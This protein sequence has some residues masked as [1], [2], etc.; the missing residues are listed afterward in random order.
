MIAT[1]SP[2]Q[3]NTEHTLNTL[4]YAYRV[5]EIRREEEGLLKGEGG[6]HEAAHG[7]RLEG[8]DDDDQV[9]AAIEVPAGLSNFLAAQQP[10]ILTRAPAV[11][12]G[13]DEDGMG[14]GGIV[15]GGEDV[16]GAAPPAPPKQRAKLLSNNNK[17]ATGNN[18]NGG[19]GGGGGVSVAS[20]A[21]MPQQSIVQ[22]LPQASA[23]Q[24][25][26]TRRAVSVSA[27]HGSALRPPTSRVTASDT[28]PHNTPLVAVESG[29][30]G[31]GGGGNGN[32]GSPSRSSAPRVTRSPLV[33]DNLRGG[34]PQQFA[35]HAERFDNL[36][37]DVARR[38]AAPR[39]SL[40]ESA[41]AAAAAAAAEA[42]AIAEAEAEAE[43]IAATATATAITAAAASMASS[44][45]H[46][47]EYFEDNGDDE[48]DNDADA[49]GD[50]D[51]DDDVDDGVDQDVEE[52]E[53]EEGDIN[54]VVDTGGEDDNDSLSPT[55]SPPPPPPPS[56]VRSPIPLS[57]PPSSP[58]VYAAA[59]ATALATRIS[60]SSALRESARLERMRSVAL[61]LT[62][63][64]LL[65]IEASLIAAHR[66]ALEESAALTA[67]ER[68]LLQE[69]SGP[70]GAL[71]R[72]DF[73][74]YAASLS[75]ALSRKIATL[76]ALARAT[77]DYSR[78]YGASVGLRDPLGE[79]TT[80]VL[81]LQ[82]IGRTPVGKVT[83]LLAGAGG[84]GGGGGRPSIGRSE[85]SP[86]RV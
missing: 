77:D 21:A 1:I 86:F 35:A 31:G 42:A 36:G 64:P 74:R 49:D 82:G 30:G 14:S 84:G 33:S 72:G 69:G 81:P 24:V 47:V 85:T 12:Y 56:K 7:T 20:R 23:L 65:P 29:G 8:A 43:A 54:V 38:A 51:D 22:A 13:L 79:E 53:E 6:A 41:A 39:G 37:G 67:V 2:S 60:P 75:D 11:G 59:A 45:H 46:H 78:N 9:S 80:S 76:G 3:I 34:S 15:S 10:R 4:R 71:T 63:A 27:Q 44:D 61:A 17:V 83:L 16:R 73:A 40:R 25:P 28:P 57:P 68:R 48:V 19:G 5:K 70:G 62:G 58:P 55:P 32:F 18:N 66:S 50:D 52:E 26:S